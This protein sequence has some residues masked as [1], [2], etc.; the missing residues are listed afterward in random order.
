MEI[1]SALLLLEHRLLDLNPFWKCPSL[2]KIQNLGFQMHFRL[3]SV[4]L[5]QSDDLKVVDLMIFGSFCL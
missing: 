5:F 4:C 3:G 1:L 2:E